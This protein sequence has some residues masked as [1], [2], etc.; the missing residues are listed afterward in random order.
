VIS[1][2]MQSQQHLFSPRSPVVFSCWVIDCIVVVVGGGATGVRGSTR[3]CSAR[4]LGAVRSTYAA[5]EVCLW[6]NPA[7]C[8]TPGSTNQASKA[9]LD[10]SHWFAWPTKPG[11]LL[12]LFALLN[13]SA[14]QVTRDR[15]MLQ[16]H[17]QYPQYNFAQH[18]VGQATRSSL[19]LGEE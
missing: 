5:Y 8:H 9:C 13:T 6:L 15:V 1:A 16:V 4:L 14:Q 18:K 10:A 2:A 12:T 11:M 17:E 7:D 3:C 19:G